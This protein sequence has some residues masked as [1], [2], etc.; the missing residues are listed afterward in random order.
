MP[1]KAALAVPATLPLPMFLRLCSRVMLGRRWSKTGLL[2]LLAKKGARNKV[3]YCSPALRPRKRDDIHGIADESEGQA[4]D[5]W[6]AGFQ[7][8]LVFR[9]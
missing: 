6:R 3:T 9:V 5:V 1:G 8:Y 7:G 4:W 2:S